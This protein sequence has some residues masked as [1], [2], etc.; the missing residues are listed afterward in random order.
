[1]PFWR[2]DWFLAEFGQNVYPSDSG[3][4]LTSFQVFV[5]AAEK[6]FQDPDSKP[7][8]IVGLMSEAQQK[9]QLELLV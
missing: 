3:G 8:S 6:I 1:M 9:M 4:P 5:L 7:G 2:S